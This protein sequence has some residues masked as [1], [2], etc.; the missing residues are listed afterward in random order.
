MNRVVYEP[1]GLTPFAICG[2]MSSSPDAGLA[3]LIAGI[4]VMRKSPRSFAGRV[5]SPTTEMP[6]EVVVIRSTP[7]NEF[8]DGKIPEKNFAVC[9]E[10]IGRASCRERV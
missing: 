1:A 8:S 4:V 6:E 10:E 3:S 2:K 5:R 9:P 7:L